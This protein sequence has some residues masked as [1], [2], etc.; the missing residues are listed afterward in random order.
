MRA[1]PRGRGSK[2]LG[3]TW[4]PKCPRVLAPSGSGRAMGQLMAKLMSIFG[5]R[6]K[7]HRSHP[8]DHSD[9]A[10]TCYPPPLPLNLRGGLGT[11]DGAPQAQRILRGGSLPAP[12]SPLPPPRP[13]LAGRALRCIPERPA[14]RASF[15][16]LN[17]VAG[18]LRS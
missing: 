7:R 4:A 15:L 16:R 12:K 17:A 14:Q 8:R 13:L 3:S 2:H 6:G 9:P 5:E 10:P 11:C 1:F 18:F